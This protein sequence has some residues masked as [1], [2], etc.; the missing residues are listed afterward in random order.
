MLEEAGGI[1]RLDLAIKKLLQ[2]KGQGFQ[3]EVA[4][5]SYAI[6]DI[7]LPA[8]FATWEYINCVEW[9]PS[10]CQL[11]NPGGQFWREV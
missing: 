11:L 4:I 3:G 2:N 6:P 8:D 9:L 7:L 10:E 5:V 1:L